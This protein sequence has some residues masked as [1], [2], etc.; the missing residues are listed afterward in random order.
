MRHIVDIL[1]DIV[2]KMSDDGL[3]IKW[4]DGSAFNEIKAPKIN[5][6]FG[7]AQYIKD[8]LNEYSQSADV[9][10]FPLIALFTP[11]RET[12]DSDMYDFKTKVNIIIA[13]SSRKD[14]TSEQRLQAS[15]KNILRPIYERLFQILRDDV[16]IDC[17]YKDILTHEY[18]ENY[19]YGRYGA[20]ADDGEAMSEPIDAID[21]RS[22]NLVINNET[23]R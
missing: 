3:S 2:S 17:G 9:V 12:R 20:Y 16:R 10:K 13:C 22:L 8:T 21:I 5:Y 6:I 11:A 23:C 18:S 15:F 7:S 4:Y 14:W 1:Q 19:S